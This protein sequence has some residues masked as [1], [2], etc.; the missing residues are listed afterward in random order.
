MVGAAALALA[1]VM[2][3]LIAAVALP[4]AGWILLVILAIVAVLVVLR[5]FAGGRQTAPRP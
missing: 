1:L 5:A 4:G 3:G 2:I